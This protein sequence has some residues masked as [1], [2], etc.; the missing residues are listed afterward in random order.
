MRDEI[1]NG[2]RT[3][4]HAGI[5]H[6]NSDSLFPTEEFES[7]LIT[8]RQR[9]RAHE[10]D[11]A[12]I[13]SPEN[14]YYLTGL[15][16]HGFFAYHL[17]IVPLTGSM[18]LIARGMEH[19]TVEE[20]VPH[21]QFTGY[22]DSEDPIAVTCAVLRDAGFARAHVGM[23]KETLFLPPHIAE[24]I[25]AGL[26]DAQWQD[27]SGLVDDQRIV[28]S[29]RELAYVR[30]AAR[31]SDAMMAAAIETTHAGAN[32]REV[33]AEAHRAMILAGGEPPGFSPFIRATPTIPQ[34]HVTWRDYELQHGDMLF[35]ELA[36]CVARYHA[37]M[38]RLLFVGEA[39]AGT[40][41]I[42]RICLEAFDAVVETI[43]PGIRA[44]D[45]YQ[46]W[47][48][49]VDAAGFSHY[50]RHHCGYSVG[51]GFPPSWV[52]GNKVVGLRHDSDLLLRAG[53]VFHLMS[54]LLGAGDGD[55]FVS[56]T[57]LVTER[58]CEVLTTTPGE[59]QIV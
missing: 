47:Q 43:R 31:V 12:L 48:D 15:N 35:V 30:D 38:G 33:A 10:V 41:T 18:R 19:P 13:S 51:I 27:I 26:P 22:N 5:T 14:I 17:L 3:T 46:A 50:R 16:H 39:P 57:A 25:Q 56:N 2:P 59:L 21:L 24:G 20:Q 32:E 55:Y 1:H 34:E 45:V 36:G 42:E 37:P 9:L 53:M 52:G 11:V 49:V 8:L 40:R 28:K 23:E 6:M 7:R 58:G 54:W 44:R 29:A 4:H